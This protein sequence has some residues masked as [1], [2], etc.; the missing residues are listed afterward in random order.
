MNR[1][2]TLEEAQELMP[3]IKALTEPAFELA[4]SLNEELHSADAR[5]DGERQEALQQRIQ[6]LVATWAEAIH[7][8]GPEVKGLW[9]V[10]FDAGDGYWCWAHPE[11]ELCH[12]HSYEGGFGARVDLRQKPQP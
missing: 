8:L 10:D 12:W 4:N 1:R 3:R 2:F 5:R 9:L 7:E 6:T 11:E